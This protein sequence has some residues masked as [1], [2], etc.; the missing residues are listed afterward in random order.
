M[1]PDALSASDARKRLKAVLHEHKKSNMEEE[2]LY[3][4]SKLEAARMAFEGTISIVFEKHLK[5][6]LHF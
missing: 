2:T 3:E 6:F 4:T 5:S 1:T